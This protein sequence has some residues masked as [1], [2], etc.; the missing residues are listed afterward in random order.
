LLS[1]PLEQERQLPEAVHDRVILYH[2]S[3][4]GLETKIVLE[5]SPIVT[6]FSHL[7]GIRIRQKQK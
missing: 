2:V 3:G 4:L 5:N 1:C 7:N 6:P